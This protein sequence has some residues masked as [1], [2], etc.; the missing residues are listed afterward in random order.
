MIKVKK[1]IRSAWSRVRP[2]R[3]HLVIACFTRSGSTY[4][5]RALSGITGFKGRMLCDAIRGNEQEISVHRLRA[6]RQRSVVQQ[7]FKA[8][9]YNV[10]LLKTYGLRPVVN[11]RNIFDCIVSLHDYYGNDSFEGQTGFVH[12]EYWAWDFDTR[13]DYL[14]KIHVP[15]YFNFYMSWRDAKQQMDTLTMT[16]ERFFADRVGC[17]QEMLEFW[18]LSAP[19]SKIEATLEILT[20]EDTVLNKGRSG[21]GDE[22][23]KDRHKEAVYDLAKIWQIDLEEMALMGLTE[24]GRVGAGAPAGR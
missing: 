2:E 24:A 14:I 16:Y 8:T 22:L 7:H 6:I 19:I 4:M 18:G 12:P 17:L 3:N 11:Y 20:P 9:T 13:I 23:L 1:G 15:W 21:R 10:G 5:R